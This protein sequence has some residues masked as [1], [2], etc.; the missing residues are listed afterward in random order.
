MELVN[1]TGERKVEKVQGVTRT[2]QVNNE[3]IALDSIYPQ[4]YGPPYKLSNPPKQVPFALGSLISISE[5]D[6]GQVLMSQNPTG[7]CQIAA[8][9]YMN[10]VLQ[11]TNPVQTIYDLYYNCRK[12][13]F[14]FDINSGNEE[15]F[16]TLFKDIFPPETIRLRAPYT[17]SNSSSMILF[18]ALTTKL[19]EMLGKKHAVSP[20]VEYKEYTIT[21][22]ALPG[23]PER[24]ISVTF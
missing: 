1:K 19:Y 17:S 14:L 24:V 12:A 20:S 15:R 13:M 22:L 6:R 16:N 18:L 11:M 8:I 23:V 21:K 4:T 7:N 3:I 2:L 9:A 5:V 10:S